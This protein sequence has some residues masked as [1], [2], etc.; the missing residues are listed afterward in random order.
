M[1][2]GRKMLVPWLA[3]LLLAALGLALN[4]RPAQ[5][6]SY[7]QDPFCQRLLAAVP[8]SKASLQVSRRAGQVYVNA[9]R[10]QGA[11]V[12]DESRRQSEPS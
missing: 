6:N 9:S 4:A 10:R 2:I 7:A 11:A 8:V 1:R 12:V 5:G 3:L